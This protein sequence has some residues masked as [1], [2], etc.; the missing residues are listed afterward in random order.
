MSSHFIKP[1][2]ENL[3]PEGYLPLR[4]TPIMPNFGAIIEGVDLTADLSDDIRAKL[5]E[6]WLRY[7]VIFLR[8]QRKFSP[9]QQLAVVTIFGTPDN[10]S[11]HVEKAT[12]QVD[13]I[14]TDANRPPVT[15]L[16][17]SDNTS[18]PIP[19]LG[20]L[21]QIQKCPPVGGNTSLACTR[22][23]YDCLS[24]KMKSYL[25]GLTAVHYWDGHGKRDSVYLDKPVDEKYFALLKKY[26]P[27][28]HPIVIE[29]PITKE[30]SL[31]VSETY[32]TY[33]KGLHKY[34]SDSVL[35]FLYSWIRMPEFYLSYQWQENDV[36]VWDNYTMQHYGLAD[37]SAE[38][39][40][41]R[42]TFVAP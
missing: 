18:L 4:V 42:V 28:E 41:Q 23:A 33:V 35:G 11:P 20:T 6:A 22:K 9:D 31:Y 37:Y 5:R 7:G 2:A 3:H 10:G 32:T 17:H 8:G 24:D 25:E 36:A 26:P 12:S 13:L 14:T 39:V 29:H 40:N 19:S 34:E 38:R 16:W 27:R 21:I 30:K 15:N 1:I